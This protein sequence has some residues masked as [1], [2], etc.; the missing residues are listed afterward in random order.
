MTAIHQDSS[1][2]DDDR[3]ARIYAGDL[4]VYSPTPAS[5]ALSE[6]GVAMVREA[7]GTYDPKKA[8][9]DMPVQEYA[10]ILAKLKPAFIHHPRC[11]ELLPQLL[12]ELGCDRERTYF[13]VPRMRTS[14]SD[15]YLTTGIAYAFHPHR[16]TWYSAPFCQINFW[17]PMFPIRAD[18]CMAFH[19]EHWSNPLK[20]SS[21]GYNYQEWNRTSRFAAATQI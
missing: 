4:F 12:S 15:K 18:N 14:T 2:S 8:Q 11:K 19:P 20:N 13:D 3:R 21:S 9:F 16:D 5:R 1:L 10:A 6:F 17:I 7:F